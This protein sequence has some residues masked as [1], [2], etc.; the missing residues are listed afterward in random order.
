MITLADRFDLERFV[1]AQ[2][3]RFEHV[4]AQLRDG[5]KQTHWMWFIFPQIQGLGRSP[6]DAHYSIKSLEEAQAYLRHPLLGPRLKECTDLVLQVQGRSAEEIFG[7]PDVLK[8]RSC[9]T[10]FANATSD[11]GV[12]MAALQKF[13]D[14]KQDTLT[15]ERI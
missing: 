5:Q 9:L 2:R 6:D 13:Y 8:F 14:S 11:N 4:C 15:L 1:D 10:L 12:F 7:F 3:D